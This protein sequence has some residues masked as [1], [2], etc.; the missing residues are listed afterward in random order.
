MIEAARSQL[1]TFIPDVY[2]Y[3]DVFKG[4]DA[5]LSSGYSLFLQAESTSGA[6]FSADGVGSAGQPVEEMSIKVAH[7]LLRQI[8]KG[9]IVDQ[10]HQWMLV[11]L[12]ALCPADLSKVALGPLTPQC[13][14]LL[15]DLKT[16]LGVSFKVVENF[17]N[18]G[19]TTVSCIG[20]GFSNLNRRTQ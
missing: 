5:G 6:I 4:D 8:Q 12:M 7:S 10:S 3:S 11:M 13:T 15:E 1:N 9:G 17:P 14:M 19:T 2:V 18:K 16:F 20:A